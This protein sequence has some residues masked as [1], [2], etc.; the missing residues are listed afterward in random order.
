MKFIGY[1]IISRAQ[2]FMTSRIFML[3]S[4]FMPNWI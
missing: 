2:M 1:F 3:A 4:I